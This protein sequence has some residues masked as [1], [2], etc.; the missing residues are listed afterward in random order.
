MKYIITLLTLLTITEAQ[1]ARDCRYGNCVK[2]ASIYQQ[3][4]QGSYVYKHYSYNNCVKE[5]Y[6]RTSITKKLSNQCEL[7][8]PMALALTNKTYPHMSNNPRRVKY[9]M[10]S[11]TRTIVSEETELREL[12][13]VCR[14]KVLSSQI[15]GS[16]ASETPITFELNNVNL[17][18]SITESFMTVAMTEDE[19]KDEMSEALRRCE[20]YRL[21]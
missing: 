9:W 3:Q 20:I 14:G 18:D 13:D 7:Q 8:T 4:P 12:V 19:A 11:Y 21:D 1:A 17:D 16:I 10:G 15:L 2:K 5:F 6:T